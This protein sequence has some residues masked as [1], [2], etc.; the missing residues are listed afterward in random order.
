MAG[1]TVASVTMA[2]TTVASV[3]T[4][5]LVTMA[6]T[7]VALAAVSVA[8]ALPMLTTAHPPSVAV[9]TTIRLVTT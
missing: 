2:G 4:V 1:T 3:T 7:T 6:G 9:L 8:A 5:A